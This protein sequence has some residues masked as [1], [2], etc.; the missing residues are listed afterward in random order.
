VVAVL[1]GATTV[2][3]AAGL[4]TSLSRVQ[5]A[6]SRASAVQVKV[7]LA[8]PTGPGETGGGPVVVA[9]DQ[10]ADPA[11]IAAAIAAQP[12][13]ARLVGV[14]QTEVDLAGSTKPLAV[15]AYH[16]DASS[17]GYQL[18]SGRWYQRPD[19]AVAGSRTLRLTGTKVGDH[20]TIGTDAGQRRVH[21]VG[22]VFGPTGQATLVMDAAGLAGLVE[23]AAPNRFE[24]ALTPRS[25][26]H[27]YVQALSAAIGSMA[28]RRR[29]P[30]TR[31]ATP[32]GSCSA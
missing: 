29:P 27:A 24:V 26:P 30:P 4:A 12:G 15:S 17:V 2:V 21:I 25:D 31:A 19:Q 1:L 9:N 6:F 23:R 20:L 14:S 5:A 28:S 18:I 11:A 16:G 7:E 13:T 8:V 10:P 32:S 3:L 22:E